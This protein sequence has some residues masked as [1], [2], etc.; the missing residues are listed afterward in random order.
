V[1]RISIPVGF[2]AC[3]TAFFAAYRRNRT[4]GDLTRG[5]RTMWNPRGENRTAYTVSLRWKRNQNGECEL[6]EISR[7]CAKRKQIK[8]NDVLGPRDTRRRKET[9]TDLDCVR[10][11]NITRPAIDASIFNFRSSIFR[12]VWHDEQQPQTFG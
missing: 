5:A 9:R 3:F 7:L 12:V 6:R 10:L 8:I 11:E 1:D 2:F 4:V